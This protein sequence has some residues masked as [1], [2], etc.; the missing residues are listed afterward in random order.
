M[1]TRAEKFAWLKAAISEGI[2]STDTALNGD[3]VIKEIEEY[4]AGLVAESAPNRCNILSHGLR[5]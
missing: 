3:E 5:Q 4:M 2:A 1:P